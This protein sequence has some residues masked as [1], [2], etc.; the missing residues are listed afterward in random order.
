MGTEVGT[1]LW[2]VYSGHMTRTKP[3]HTPSSIYSEPNPMERL[4][5]RATYDLR[6]AQLTLDG[7]DKDILRLRKLARHYAEEGNHSAKRSANDHA[8]RRVL[9]QRKKT[10]ERDALQQEL[11]V[12][13]VLVA[14]H[15]YWVPQPRFWEQ[16][17]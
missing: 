2:T 13:K 10:V 11:E 8:D 7:I 9:E 4:V 17:S 16:Q 14:N 6:N 5:R 1:A 15:E 3:T 12:L